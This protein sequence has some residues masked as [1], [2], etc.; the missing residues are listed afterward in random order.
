MTHPRKSVLFGAL[1]LA[2]LA[3]FARPALGDEGMWLLNVPPVEQVKRAYGVDLTASWLTEMQRSAV[4]FDGA[5]GSLVTGDGLVMTNHHVGSDAIAKLSTPERD[6]LRDGFYAATRDQELKC[7]DLELK[8]L[9]EIRDVTDRVIGAGKA[10]EGSAAAGSARRA[11]MAQIEQE[12]GKAT[13]LSCEVVTLYHGAR[14]HLYCS[15]RHTDVRLVFAPEQQIAF[16]GGDTDN[17]EYPRYNLDVAFF[18]IYENGVPLKPANHLKWSKGGSSEGELAFVFGHPGA[19]RRLYTMDHLRFRRDTELPWI[20]RRLWRREVQLEVFR[21]RSEA[22][23][24]MAAEDYFGVANSRKRTTSQYEGL[25]NPSIWNAKAEDERKVRAFLEN[26]PSLKAKWGGAW[27]DIAKAQSEFRVFFRRWSML[28]QD[29]SWGWSKL[30]SNARHV[31]R[32]ADELPKPSAGRLREYRDSNL[33]ALYHSLYS[34]APVYPALEV[35]R[36]AGG[37][38]FLAE[39]LGAEDDLV[40]ALLAGKSP[41]D[42]AA[43][44][45]SGSVLADPSSVRAMVEGGPAA[46]HASKDPMLDF[47]RILDPEARRLRKQYE[48]TVEAVERESYAK[49]AGAWFDLMGDRLYPDA[50]GTLRMT[51]G[52]VA[53]YTDPTPREQ[54]GEGAVPAFTTLDGLYERAESR[55]M[56]PPFDLPGSWVKHRAALDPK[57]AFNF[58]VMADI[59]GGNSGS[60]VVNAKG[61]VTGLIFDSNL[62][63]LVSD[64][65][66]EPEMGR[67]VAVDSRAIVEALRKVYGAGAL[68]DELEK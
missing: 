51:F 32:L 7:A 3:L 52:K 9:W 66:Y 19:T 60:P 54:G 27:D 21:G 12:V 65:T 43:E 18:R 6:I 10:G 49:V 4:N 34:P 44:L 22:Q 64:F 25:L 53:G 20:L 1:A 8:V 36:L 41:R 50:T 61:E 33:E 48:D 68:A 37:L 46:V 5:S 17:F 14:Y 59:I 16:F 62:H 28:N 35:D 58:I 40:K 2:H 39:N 56:Q 11:E 63:H 29:S 31:L 67:A 15:K 24:L 42:R 45:V 47:V 55:K 13:G 30:L 23:S 26:N 57:T 38:M